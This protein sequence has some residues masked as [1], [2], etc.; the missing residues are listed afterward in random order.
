MQLQRGK[1]CHLFVVQVV[2]SSAVH[3]RALLGDVGLTCAVM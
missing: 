2:L 1:G 3:G